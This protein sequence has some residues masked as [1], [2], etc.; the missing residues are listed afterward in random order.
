[1]RLN[2]EAPVNEVELKIEE[3]L[4]NSGIERETIQ[5]RGSERYLS[6]GYWERLPNDVL[7]K[8]GILIASEDDIFDDDC[9]WLYMYRTKS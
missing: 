3:I 1:M 8:L 5:F 6:I 4:V 7:E 2:S 9:G